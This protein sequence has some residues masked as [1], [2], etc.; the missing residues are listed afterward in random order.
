MLWD[1]TLP[2][3][4]NIFYQNF[5]S[6]MAVCDESLVYLTKHL[7]WNL[8]TSAHFEGVWLHA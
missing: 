8:T 4:V 6:V 1:Y 5:S 3:F 7:K 2:E